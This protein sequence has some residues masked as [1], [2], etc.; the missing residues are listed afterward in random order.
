MPVLDGFGLVEKIRADSQL[1]DT[2]VL[3]VSSDDAP[4]QIA[5][6]AAVGADEYVVKGKY[7]QHELLE[8]VARYLGSRDDHHPDR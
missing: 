2:P 4:E 1:Q 7:E 3:L 8:T 5:R 6:G